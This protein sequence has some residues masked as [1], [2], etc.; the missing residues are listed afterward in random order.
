MEL[1]DDSFREILDGVLGERLEVLRGV[2]K[3]SQAKRTKRGKKISVSPGKSYTQ[4]PAA[5]DD[6]GS[7]LDDL[8]DL[9]DEVNDPDDIPLSARAASKKRR[10]TI[11]TGT[12][13]SALVR[14]KRAL[15]F[16]SENPDFSVPVPDDQ[17]F[18][19]PL[20]DFDLSQEEEDIDQ[21]ISCM[22]R[23]IGA[24]GDN[25]GNSSEEEASSSEEE[26]TG[27]GME[28]RNS[29]EEDE[30]EA[31]ERF[32]GLKRPPKRKPAGKDKALHGFVPI[33]KASKFKVG[34]WVAAVYHDAWYICQVEGEEDEVDG[35]TLL[36]Y[37]NRMGRNQFFWDSRPDVLKTVNT[38][39]LGFTDAP[40]PVSNRYMGYPE[41]LC[42]KL[43]A[44]LR[45]WWF[46]FET[47]SLLINYRYWGIKYQY[48]YL[49]F[50]G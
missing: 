43:D 28:E 11:N 31:L 24:Q 33:T 2:D 13:T 5:T 47:K 36:R 25:D 27:T 10:G 9:L 29:S 50:F 17:D 20:P 40:V 30:A 42:K 7:E 39:I 18:D 35:Y 19:I 6:S 34:N 21:D 15:T 37:M 23:E 32:L 14:K 4:L 16:D 44:G 22:A 26:E 38:D 45:L 8:D 3:A 12:G 49:T 46:I 41:L 1:E 48:R